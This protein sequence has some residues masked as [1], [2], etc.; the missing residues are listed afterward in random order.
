MS[1]RVQSILFFL[2]AF[3]FATLFFLPLAEYY[4]ELNILRFNAYGVES[5]LPNGESPF[6]NWFALPVLILTVTAI[7]LGVYLSVSL[8]KAVKMA[9]FQRLHRFAKINVVVIVAWIA[10]ACVYNFILTKQPGLDGPCFSGKAF[11]AFL[12]LVAL[13][14]S[15]LASNGL[16]KDI[17]RVRST[18]RIR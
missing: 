1:Q 7:L 2:S 3:L 8:L 11:G 18:D 15:V 16:K 9:Q 14:F 17:K 12:P 5:L 13:L 4:G 6:G 10:V